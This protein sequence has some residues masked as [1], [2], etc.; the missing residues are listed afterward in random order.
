MG[1]VAGV[2]QARKNVPSRQPWVVCQQFIL[3]LAGRQEFENEL[4][5]QTRP[6]DHRF[7]GQDLG[8]DVNALR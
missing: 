5:G 3:G 7:A 4:N 8:V 2:R 1:Q 6:P